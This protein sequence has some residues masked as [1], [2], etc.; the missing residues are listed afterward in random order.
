MS[1]ALFGLKKSAPQSADAPDWVKKLKAAS[2]RQLETALEQPYLMALMIGSLLL[3]FASFF[4]TFA[5]MLNFMPVWVISF[6]ITFAV[7]ALLFVTSWRIGFALADKESVPYFSIFVFAICLA[8][9]VFFSWVALFES[10]NDEQ[11]QAR[12]RDTRMHRAVED[13]VSELQ[14]RAIERRREQVEALL[15][16]DVFADWRGSVTAVADKATS[17]RDVLED[18]LRARAREIAGKIDVLQRQKAEILSREATAAERLETAK[19]ELARLDEA[20]PLLLDRVNRLRGELD[21]AEEAVVLKEG[22]MQA[23]ETGGGEDRA[24][25]RGPVWRQLRDERNILAA[26]RDTKRRLFEAA[27]SEL[28]EADRRIEALK[29]AAAS[30]GAVGVDAQVE[31]IDREIETLRRAASG[32]ED[33]EGVNLDAEV[34]QLRANLSAFATRFDLAPFDAAAAKCAELLEA[35]QNNP[36]L[37]PQVAGLSCDTALMAEYMN[38]IGQA[39]TDLRAFEAACAPGGANAQTVTAM[40]FTEATKYGRECIG[41]SG[42]PADA[43]SDL[44]SEIDRLVLEED[45][46]ASR[47]VKTVNA[48]SGGEKLSYFALAIAGAIDF[49]VL[50][51]GLIG[52]VSTRPKISQHVGRVSDRQK[53]ANVL[54]ALTV[55]LDPDPSDSKAVQVAK[56]VLRSVKPVEPSDNAP[57]LVERRPDAFTVEARIEMA[58]LA[59][60]GAAPDVRQLLVSLCGA[61]MAESHTGWIENTPVEIFLIRTGFLDVLREVIE[62]HDRKME[63]EDPTFKQRRRASARRLTGPGSFAALPS[64]EAGAYAG[65]GSPLPGYAESVQARMVTAEDAAAAKRVQRMQQSPQQSSR[66]RSGAVAERPSP[67]RATVVDMAGARVQ[68]EGDIAQIENPADMTPETQSAWLTNMIDFTRRE[69]HPESEADAGRAPRRPT[70]AQT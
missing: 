59:E 5:G 30:G 20:R 53:E 46:D 23:E 36:A 1:V 26:A 14:A 57:Q 62:E 67:R 2:G 50:F 17:A 39:E 28:G 63:D 3:S 42:L 8:T 10:I 18:A 38:P 47:F 60:P 15:D 41:V 29:A 25:G 65:G 24:A 35:M 12:T 48:F 21:A 40:S 64:P 27:Q 43:V 22:Q 45:P 4:T 56:I 68:A 11:L 66:R 70:R 54:R 19:R 7:Q 51:S 37:A 55:N 13:A 31:T 9:S 6:C 32:G 69:D 44:R 52:A 34:A 61:Q 58:A 16:S 49:L 33:G